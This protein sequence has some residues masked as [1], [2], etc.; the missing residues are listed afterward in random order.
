MR[1]STIFTFI[2]TVLTDGKVQENYVNHLAMICNLCKTTPQFPQWFMPH[3]QSYL[4]KITILHA[5]CTKSMILDKIVKLLHFFLHHFLHYIYVFCFKIRSLGTHLY[6]RI[7]TSVSPSA[8][9]SR[10][11]NLVSR[12]FLVVVRSY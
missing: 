3:L 4:S 12:L 6:E 7:S 9:L 5:S 2:L 1:I 11:R 8:H 10:L